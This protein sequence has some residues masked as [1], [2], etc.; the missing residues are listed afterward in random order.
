MLT[1]REG[2]TKDRDDR[3]VG[4]KTGWNLTQSALMCCRQ[5]GRFLY[6]KADQSEHRLSLGASTEQQSRRSRR[7]INSLSALT[8]HPM[9]NRVSKLA[10]MCLGITRYHKTPLFA[11]Y[12]IYSLLLQPSLRKFHQ[13]SFND[14]RS[15]Q[16]TFK[17]FHV[18]I[19]RDGTFAVFRFNK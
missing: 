13:V 12:D 4:P 18:Q 14:I 9:A 11:K 1:S 6:P 5:N 10:G 15:K 17:T 3:P 8:G 19:D 2:E 16:I 7:S